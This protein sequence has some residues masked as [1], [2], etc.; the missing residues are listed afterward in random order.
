MQVPRTFLLLGVIIMAA[1]ILY[2]VVL[3]DFFEE[4]SVLIG[5]PWFHLSMIDLYVGFFLFGGWIA[6]RE[7]SMGCT[8]VWLVLLCSLGNLVACLYA[9][10]AVIRSE[11]DWSRFWM[12]ARAICV[13]SDSA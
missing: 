11:G 10:L 9:L 12:G 13:E 8:I 5:L 6:Y 3:G 7:R 1:A 4:A 2:A